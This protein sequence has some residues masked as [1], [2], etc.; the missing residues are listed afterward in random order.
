MVFIIE[1][2]MLFAMMNTMIV[3][4]MSRQKSLVIHS[5]VMMFCEEKMAST[6]TVR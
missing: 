4:S 2:K 3:L 6:F 1:P 5:K